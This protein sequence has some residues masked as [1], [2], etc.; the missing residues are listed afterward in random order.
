MI[1][2]NVKHILK[3]ML[4]ITAVFLTGYFLEEAIDS[5]IT[6][7]EAL[8]G[9]LEVAPEFLAIFVSFSI[10][11]ITWHA[12]DKS[13][14]NH[15]LFIGG[16][17]F[18]VGFLILLHT[19][20]YPFMPDFITKNTHQKSAIFF[21]MSRLILAP[22][23]L[24]SAFV[25]KDTCPRLTRKP[26]LLALIIFLSSVSFIT[27]LNYPVYLPLMGTSE[28]RTAMSIST[29]VIL[30]ATYLYARR[31]RRTNQKN[32]IFLIYGSICV[33]VSDLIYFYYELSGHL[34]IITGFLFMYL[35]MYR[36]AIELP[37]EKLSQAE[38]RFRSV[39]QSA[40]EAIITSDLN[41]RIVFWNK[42]AQNMFGYENEDVRGRPVA[43]LMPERYRDAHKKGLERLLSNGEKHI[44]GKMI[45]LH[46]LRKDGS[47]FPFE[48][49]LGTWKSG[50]ET[51]YSGFL[52]DISERKKGEEVRNENERLAYVSKAKSEFLA[53]MSHELRTPLNSIIG[54]SELMKQK[55]IG[56][57]NIKQEHYL[58]NILTSSRFLLNLINDI[59][60]ISKVEAGKIELIIEKLHVPGVI[61]ETISL[62]KEKAAKQNIE[63]KTELDPQLDFIEADQQ[64]F[65]QVLFNLLS[66]AVK[67]S[68]RGGGSITIT[69]KKDGDMARISV[70]DTGIGIK[71]ED[72]GK[73][74]MEFEQIDSGISRR[75]GGTGLG[76]AISKKLVELHGGSITVE[77]KHG[78]GST[79][80]FWIPVNAIR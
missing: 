24:A 47:E 19:F 8:E 2:E 7:Q 49:S 63:L 27:G 40:N 1:S 41:G 52:R 64:R 38:E 6:N 23:L 25:Y 79:F 5:L 48:L 60:D 13:R 43:L 4:I 34:L 62:I 39:A 51:F 54:F 45:E 77:S 76:L 29:G 75:Y 70:A 55:K 9:Y 30:C 11:T 53:N 61:N 46:G 65:K 14:D 80:T 33:V 69:A 20:S 36:S 12:Y 3:L 17:F 56:E 71:E 42:R 35:G 67:F 50:N 10:F 22:L 74:F 18:V 15:S 32:L 59:L 68:K 26:V 28:I 44:I 58:N 21:I 57:L 72:I 73:L 16:T 78:E 66:N 31:F 37:Y